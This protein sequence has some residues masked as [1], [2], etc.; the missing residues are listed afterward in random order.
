MTRTSWYEWYEFRVFTCFLRCK[1]SYERRYE[2]GRWAAGGTSFGRRAG[3]EEDRRD[4]DPPRLVRVGTS[5]TS[6]V[7]L[8]VFCDVKTRTSGGTSLSG[9]QGVVRVLA[10][11]PVGRRTA[12]TTPRRY[13]SELVRMGRVDGLE[14]FWQFGKLEPLVP[15]RTGPVRPPSRRS[16]FQPVRRLKLVPPAAHRPDSHRRSYEFLHCK[17]K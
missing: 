10:G 4:G 5:G 15:T 12:Q 2:S 1:N 6:F 13:S 7:F 8:L 16:S 14:L 11:G 17:N 3:R 9:R